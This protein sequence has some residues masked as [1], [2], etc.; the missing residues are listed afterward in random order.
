ME[1]DLNLVR[2]HLDNKY[3]EDSNFRRN[4][5][6]LIRIAEKAKEGQNGSDRD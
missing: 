1:I 4:V 6:E 2:E 5:E 3:Y